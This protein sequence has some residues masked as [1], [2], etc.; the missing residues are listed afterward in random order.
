[1]IIPTSDYDPL[2]ADDGVPFRTKMMQ[3]IE[4]EFADLLGSRRGL[5]KHAQGL[6][7]LSDLVV[8]KPDRKTHRA[9]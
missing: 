4:R 3:Y 2:F 9:A 5:L 1:M 6:E 8:R 7:I